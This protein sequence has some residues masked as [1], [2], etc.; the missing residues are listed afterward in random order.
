MADSAALSNVVPDMDG[1]KHK[2]ALFRNGINEA[3]AHTPS[4]FI[5]ATALVPFSGGSVLLTRL[6][7]AWAIWTMVLICHWMLLTYHVWWAFAR[8]TARL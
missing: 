4:D 5:S 8:P 1:Y 3:H 2:P 7:F 6:A